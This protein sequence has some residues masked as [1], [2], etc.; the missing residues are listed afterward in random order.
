M[1]N[2][3]AKTRSNWFFSLR[4]KLLAVLIPLLVVSI[5]L[6]MVGLGK[7]LQDFFQ[8]TAE[9][10]T[11]QLGQAVKATLRQSMLRKP[12]LVVTDM[13]G[14]LQKAPNI[15]RVWIIDR[16]GRIAHASDRDMV[17]KVM[18]KRADPACTA[19]HAN[20]DTPQTRTF[21]TRDEA[22]IPVIRHVSLIQ[23]ERAC[24]ACHDSKVRLNG[25][26]LLD[27][28]TETFHSAFWTVERRLGATGGITLALLIAMSFVVTTLFVERP[29]RRLTAG[30]RQL[31]TG[32]LTVRV[33]ARGRDELAEL[34]GSFN[35]MAG[36][37]NRS[38]AE[39]R[40]KNAELSIVYF[41][42]ERLTRTI[43]L[44]E[45]REIILQ[46]MV[47]VLGADQV[48]LVSNPMGP[49]ALEVILKTR[50]SSRVHRISAPTEGQVLLP[51]GFPSEAAR[52]WLRGE[53]QEP[54]VTPERQVVVIPVQAHDERFALLLVKR[55]SP[56]KHSEANPE[57]LDALAHHIGVAFENAHLYTLAI[58]DE[59]TKLYT[60]RHLRHQMENY[61][62]RYKRHEEM[63]GLLMLDLDH[64][65]SINDTWGHPVGDDVL[66]RV[67]HILL[68]NVR[69]VDSAYRYGGEEFVVLLPEADPA[70]TRLVAERVRQ[71]IEGMEFSVDSGERI[72]VTAS[73]GLAVYPD[74]GV[75]M[76]QLVA[77][78]DAAL[79]VAKRGGRNRVCDPP[80]QF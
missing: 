58:T 7:F 25:I 19:C 60:V 32:D 72:A 10:E 23:N 53:L 38:L 71:K 79:Y 76:P 27:E 55:G 13:L 78:A 4:M 61:I 47:D 51:E 70:T 66:R 24:W 1:N 42:L 28:S 73:I 9:L 29:V 41:I 3:P 68:Q 22:G 77:A 16:I 43:D 59:L 56:F 50:D 40:S 8:Q 63:F 54:F 2:T 18:D 64:F 35:Q 69:T 6:A 33:P 65:K 30:V 15:R 11:D 67:A 62:S 37:L 12:V 57:L 34:A 14:D 80:K 49:D 17:G 44:G 46:T 21:F 5:L 52:R 45:L 74:D 26:L 75:S 36:D 48:L 20:G 39:I 31:A